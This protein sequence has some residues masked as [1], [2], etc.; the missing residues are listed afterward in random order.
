MGARD[1]FAAGALAL[2]LLV[3]GGLG[4]ATTE[5]KDQTTTSYMTPIPPPGRILV[6]SF[7]TSPEDIQLDYSPT[8]VAAWKLEGRSASTERRDV[9]RAVSGAVADHLVEKIHAMGLPAEH[10]SGPIE[11]NPSTTTILIEGQFIA[12]D[13]GSR[14]ERVVIGLGAGR[15]DVRTEVQ[16]MELLPYGHRPLDQFEIVAKSGRKPGAA[17]T[18]AVGAGAGTLVTA[19]VVTAATA[20]SSEAFGADVDADARRTADKIASVLKTYFQRQGWIA[21][22]D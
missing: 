4:C 9:D 8:V 20:V 14:A 17:E 5:V 22:G 12:I 7:A 16:V 11:V 6:R 1:V 15:S 19:G 21:A 18:L 10:V 13:E 2:L 3:S